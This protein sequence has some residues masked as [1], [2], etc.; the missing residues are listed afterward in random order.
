MT[1]RIVPF[2]LA[3]L[4]IPSAARAGDGQ[5]WVSAGASGT[6][7]GKVRGSIDSIGRYDRDGLYEWVLSGAVGYRIDEHFTLWAGYVHKSAYANNRTSTEQR[8]RQD[9]TFDDIARI[10]PVR[11]GGRLRAEERWRDDRPGTGWRV[12]PQFKLTLPLRQDGPALVAAVE[13]LV[14]L[15]EG[16]GQRAGYDRTRASFGV[17]APLSKAVRLDAGYLRQTTRGAETVDAATLGLNFRW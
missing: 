13:G 14:N 12:R 10:G 17:Q 4:I 1:L 11:V 15:G 6:I 3:A 2:A 5:V 16:A 7:S 9:L 8:A